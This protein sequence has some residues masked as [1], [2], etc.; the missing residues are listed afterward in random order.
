MHTKYFNHFHQHIITHLPQN[1]KNELYRRE[2]GAKE[3]KDGL[4]GSVV[5]KGLMKEEDVNFSMNGKVG[6]KGLK[7]EKY[8]S[9]NRGESQY[10]RR[11]EKGEVGEGI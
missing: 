1:I 2:E 11:S 9:G 8:E 4:T 6:K 7:G 5:T 10:E 3:R